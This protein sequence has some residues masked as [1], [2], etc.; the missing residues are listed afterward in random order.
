MD[1]YLSVFFK[2]LPKDVDS[3]IKALEKF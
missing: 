2:D 1:K 3:A